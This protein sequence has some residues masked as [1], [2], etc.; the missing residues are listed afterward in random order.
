MEFSVRAALSRIS[1]FVTSK[2]K[3]FCVSAGKAM[4]RRVA[5]AFGPRFRAEVLQIATLLVISLGFSYF[6]IPRILFCD[7]DE[8]IS[9]GSEGET[10]ADRTLDRLMA[11]SA[12]QAEQE[13]LASGELSRF[14]VDTLE[15]LYRARS[16]EEAYWEWEN[17]R[18]ESARQDA[19][20]ASMQA[21]VDARER[22]NER[23][24]KR[25]AE[26]SLLS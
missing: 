22:D 1:N 25:G 8:Q 20:I 16:F 23:P 5:D 4:L 9:S 24:R 14:V 3:K 6:G 2:S 18:R 7:G 15:R 13:E 19:E 11:G 12:S 21:R 17:Q 26:G 10:E